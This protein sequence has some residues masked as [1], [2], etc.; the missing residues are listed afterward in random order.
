[1]SGEVEHH[2]ARDGDRRV[3]AVVVRAL[4]SD[5]KALLDVLDSLMG[6]SWPSSCCSR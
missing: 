2:R 4:E 3:L 5:R 6:S 1:M